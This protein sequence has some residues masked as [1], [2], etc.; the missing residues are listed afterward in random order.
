[1]KVKIVLRNP[2]NKKD[3]IDYSIDV[4][5][6][7]LAQD[8]I[9]ALEKILKSG[10]LLEKNYCFMGFPKTHR[11]VDYLCN[12]LNQAVEQINKF[13]ITNT[14]QSHGLP[15]F[16]IEDYYCENTVRWSLSYGI[17][18]PTVKDNLTNY[19]P[20]L[21]PKH[22]M[23]NRL[24]NY[25][26]NLQGT[27]DQL[28]PYYKLADHETKY[29]IRQLNNCCHELENVILSQRKE[30][31]SPYWVRPSQ[32]NTW[33]NADRYK[34]E[35]EHRRGFTHNGYDRVLGGVYMHWAQIGK[36]LFEV[37]RDENAPELTETVCEAITHLEYYSGEFDIEWGNDVVYDKKHC[38][39]HVEEQDQFR[40]W[41]VKNN[42]DPSDTKL[43]LGYLP[44]G[45][46]DL[47]GSFGT[48]DY[49]TIW[50]TL[51]DHLDIYR[52]EVNNTVAE[53]DYCWSDSDYKQRQI[54]RMRAGYDYQQRKI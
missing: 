17:G 22:G 32:I 25:F 11:N 13:C 45:Q 43:S 49:Q 16:Y 9:I 42:L 6:H 27:V 52:I 41:L 20:G 40:A 34:L 14:W 54:D 36:T 38:P 51:G 46:V 2:V 10:N 24:H 7:K 23:L 5:D 48:L 31:L 15:E 18:E 33:L 28:S 4:H 37:W 50:N 12:Q 29:A 21:M 30:V 39:W 19:R 47:L 44:I 26:E 3:Q 1:M 35:D 53:Y 8:W